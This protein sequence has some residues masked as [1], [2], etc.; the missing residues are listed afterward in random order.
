MTSADRQQVDAVATEAARSPGAS[1]IRT[2]LDLPRDMNRALRRWCALAAVEAD[3]ATV[4]M[5]TVLRVLVEVL[6]EGEPKDEPLR[7]VELKERLQRAVLRGVARVHD[8]DRR[9]GA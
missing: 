4:P 8:P 3:V 1:T 6:L 7:D 2:T 5:T 9:D